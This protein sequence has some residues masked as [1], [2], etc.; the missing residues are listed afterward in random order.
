VKAVVYSKRPDDLKATA[1]LFWVRYLDNK[2]NVPRPI[3]VSSPVDIM[4]AL[5]PTLFNLTKVDLH[6]GD[7]GSVA[8][9]AFGIEK[10]DKVYL[11]TDPPRLRGDSTPDKRLGYVPFHIMVS[12]KDF[13]AGSSKMFGIT[14]GG[15]NDFD[16][17]YL[18]E[19]TRTGN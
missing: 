3:D 13:S 16:V 5:R 2:V 4:D 15:W 1:P 18:G 10:T 12:R 11:A 19:E 8:I 7:A 9:V 14:T 6:R 17:I